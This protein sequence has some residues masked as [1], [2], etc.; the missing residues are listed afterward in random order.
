MRINYPSVL[1]GYYKVGEV[2]DK[3]A[4]ERARQLDEAVWIGEKRKL[5]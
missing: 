2:L 1:S 4:T 3:E 5:N